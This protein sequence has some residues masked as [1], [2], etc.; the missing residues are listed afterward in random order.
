MR[1]RSYEIGKPCML[2][3]PHAGV[4]NKRQ[5]RTRV[6]AACKHHMTD[7]ACANRRLG[8]AAHEGEILRDRQPGV[9]ACPHAA[10]PNKRRGRTRVKAACQHHMADTPC[11]NRPMRHERGDPT[12]SASPAH[13]SNICTTPAARLPGGRAGGGGGGGGGSLSRLDAASLTPPSCDH[14]ANLGG[15]DAALPFPGSH[16]GRKR[17]VESAVLFSTKKNSVAFRGRGEKGG[18]WHG[19]QKT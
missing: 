8:N 12:R 17:R 5:S 3:C 11:A 7:A 14:T 10:V 4:S 13:K 1:A 15:A 16:E 6:K 19:P 9:L 2:A 18:A